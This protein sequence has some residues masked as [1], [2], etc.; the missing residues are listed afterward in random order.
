MKINAKYIRI[1][2]AEQG[3]TNKALGE[4]CGIHPTVISRIIT[5]GTAD[6]RTIGKL[7]AGLSIPVAE[8]MAE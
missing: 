7:A 4:S 5:R 1:K 2:M 6:Y 8:V 3:L